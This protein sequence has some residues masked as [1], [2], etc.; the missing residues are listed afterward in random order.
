MV[1]QFINKNDNNSRKILAGN[2]TDVSDMI[3]T[4]YGD[5]FLFTSILID[6]EEQNIY[7]ST[8]ILTKEEFKAH[9]DLQYGSPMMYISKEDYDWLL[10]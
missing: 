1:K 5:K 10:I 3:I 6:E 9:F 4:K 8:E 7:P 2:D